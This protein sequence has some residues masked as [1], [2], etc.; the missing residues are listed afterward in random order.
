VS[1]YSGLGI[2]WLGEYD[3]DH[4]FSVNDVVSFNGSSYICILAHDG[5]DPDTRPETGVAWTTYWNVLAQKGDS[6]YSGYSGKSGFSGYSG[7]SGFSGYSG[8]SGFSGY[9]GL[10]GFSGYSGESGYSGY[11]GKSGYSG[12]SGSQGTKGD[13]GSSGFSGYSGISGFSG[14]SGVSGF[15]GYSGTSGYSGYSGPSNLI[16][17]VMTADQSVNNTTTLATITDMACSIGANEIW[18]V[19]F[20]LYLTNVATG[21][22]GATGV[23]FQVTNPSSPNYVM[24]MVTVENLETTGFFADFFPGGG[25]SS[26]SPTFTLSAAAFTAEE[27]NIGNPSPTSVRA[28]IR[29]T[30]SNAANAGTIQL[31]MAQETAVSG[32]LTIKRGSALLATKV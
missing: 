5:N 31:K 18:T 11:S 7:L 25:A 3:Y 6:G 29:F 23:K 24:G 2:Y 15:S 27:A 28:R 1:G 26:T 20:D 30:I 13:P 9:S 14:Y 10:S 12:Y 16:T 19:E 17:K 22:F 8:I 32:N 21:S 4:T